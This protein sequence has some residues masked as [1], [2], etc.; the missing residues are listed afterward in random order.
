MPESNVALKK[1][2]TW[3]PG[4]ALTIGAVLGSGILVLPAAAA[5]IAGPASLVAWALMALLTVPVAFT[6]G[7]LAVLRPDAGGIA[8]YAR[9]AFGGAGR[10]HNGLAVSRHSAYWGTSGSAD[11]RPV[12]RDAVCLVASGNGDASGAAG[13]R[14]GGA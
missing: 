8:A 14:G 10:L 2:L 4:A 5:V 13:D 6:L 12:H 1:S 9:L 7:R 3:L 11:W